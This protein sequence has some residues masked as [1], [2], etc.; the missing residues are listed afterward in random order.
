MWNYITKYETI[1]AVNQ[2][3]PVSAAMTVAVVT[4]FSYLVIGSFLFPV[5]DRAVWPSLTKLSGFVVFKHFALFFAVALTH[6]PQ[7]SAAC[8]LSVPTEKVTEIKTN[9]F[10]TSFG[11]VSDT[12]MVSCSLFPI[13]QHWA[14]PQTL[15]ASSPDY[16]LT[17]QTT[18]L[19]NLWKNRHT[20][21]LCCCFPAGIHDRRVLPPELE[22]R[23]ALLQRAHGDA[24]PEQPAGQ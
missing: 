24:A 7:F 16:R 12:E 22:R 13:M 17:L 6:Y 9:I 1:S 11:P 10:V 14:E 15:H 21:L 18:L 2:S 5:H 8:V 23:A 19:I 20:C 4:S 3:S